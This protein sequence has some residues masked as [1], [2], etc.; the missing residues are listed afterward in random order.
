MNSSYTYSDEVFNHERTIFTYG[1]LGE[2]KRFIIEEYIN[3]NKYDSYILATFD[4][5]NLYKYINNKK[6]VKWLLNM[7]WQR[8]S[9][10][11]ANFKEEIFYCSAQCNNYFGVSYLLRHCDY[12]KYIAMWLDVVNEHNTYKFERLLNLG[13]TI[14]MNFFNNKTIINHNDLYSHSLFKWC[15]YRLLEFNNCN[16]SLIKLINDNM[17]HERKMQ[18][19][20]I[21]KFTASFF[22]F[23]NWF[24]VVYDGALQI[25]NQYTIL[26]LI[27]T[28]AIFGKSMHVLK[29]INRCICMH[30]FKKF[31]YG[32]YSC[33]YISKRLNKNTLYFCL[34]NYMIE[35]NAYEYLRKVII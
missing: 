32:S 28:K 35:E 23:N 7:N 12:I 20:K 8:H 15:I 13:Y 31:L 11:S 3:D 34:N 9:N 16:D 25:A 14:G 30:T 4:S 29:F 22:N 5:L 21:K 10:F 26:N 1:T 6:V 18:S 17:F 24:Y 27:R 33:V 2:V 19:R